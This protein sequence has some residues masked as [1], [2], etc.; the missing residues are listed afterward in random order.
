MNELI[1]PLFG[2]LGIALGGAI[3]YATTRRDTLTTAYQHLVE[4]QANSKN[5][6]TPKTRKTR[7][8]H[9]KPRRTPT[10]QRPRNRLHPQ[11]RPLARPILRNHR[12]PGIPHTPP[13]AKPPQ[14]TPRPHLPTLTQHNTKKPRHTTGASS[15]QTDHDNHIRPTTTW[16]RKS[17]H[18]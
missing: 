16:L 12:R 8:T 3:T 14:R 10:R 4:A 6:S 11:T 15:Y 13:Q 2:L 7:Q 17:I 5:K 9:R 1:S 18:P